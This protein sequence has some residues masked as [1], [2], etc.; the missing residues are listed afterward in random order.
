[1]IFDLRT[2]HLG[3]VLLAMP[4]MRAGDGVIARA[5]HRVPGLVVDWM[6]AGTGTRATCWHNVHCTDAWL[7]ATGREP[8]RHALLPEA[9]R[10]LTVIAPHVKAKAKQWRG[11]R[12]LA[13]ELAFDCK[14]LV[15]AT[16]ELGRVAWMEL[17]SRAHTVICPDTGTAHMA[18]ALGCPRVVALHGVPAN[19][20][21]CAPYWN[22]GHCV[23]RERMDDITVGDVLEVLHG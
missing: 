4:A 6:D 19:W 15:L 9:E 23:V 14:G 8:V 13:R 12:D 20:P 10:E 3:D 22:R 5:E 17:L 18:D 21:R 2:G 11:W 7:R 1:M 16:A